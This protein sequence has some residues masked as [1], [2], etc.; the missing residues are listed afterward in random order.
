MNAVGD[1]ALDA[2]DLEE[3]NSITVSVEAETFE[4][5]SV[6]SVKHGEHKHKGVSVE[7]IDL[8]SDIKVTFLCLQI[9]FHL[10]CNTQDT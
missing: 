5:N 4:T 2:D 7:A 10:I 3:R 9:G 6:G 8:I 1:M